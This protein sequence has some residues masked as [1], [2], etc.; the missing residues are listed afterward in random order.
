MSSFRA[1]GVEPPLGIVA[2][3]LLALRCCDGDDDDDDRD[4]AAFVAHAARTHEVLTEL[5]QI[6]LHRPSLLRI[7]VTYFISPLV[8]LSL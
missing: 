4:F 6:C 7:I 2:A 8:F 5:R 1:N 3:A